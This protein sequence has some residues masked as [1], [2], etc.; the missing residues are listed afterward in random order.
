MINLIPKY[1]FHIN[2]DW[3]INTTQYR[4]FC[5][6]KWFWRTYD[7]QFKKEYDF[8]HNILGD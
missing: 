3:L 4:I 1:E 6:R 7:K 2:Y 8:I 5:L